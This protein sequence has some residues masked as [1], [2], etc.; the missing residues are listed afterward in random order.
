MTEFF[1]ENGDFTLEIS[2][3]LRQ[4][5]SKFDKDQD[6]LLSRKELSAFVEDTN[7]SS[8]CTA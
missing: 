5:F 3:L 6:M 8:V 1:A 4:L 2:D 7:E